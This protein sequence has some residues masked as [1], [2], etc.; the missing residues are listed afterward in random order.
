MI[1]L[2]T[3]V[4]SE[5]WR[6]VPDPAVRAWIDAQ[7]VETLYLS[8]VTVAELRLGIAVMSAGKRQRTYR[9]R[10][11]R[12]VLPAFA[13]RVL[14]FDLDAARHYAD[15]MAQAKTAG[16]AIAQA[17]GHIAA[18]AAARGFIVA[19]RDTSPFEAA[20]VRVVDPWKAAA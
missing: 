11:E 17:D 10:L 8:A 16:R 4:I 18:I 7:V 5:L 13:G 19:S 15:F 1:V 2:D 20:G 6:V 9:D 3:N 14:P 12:E